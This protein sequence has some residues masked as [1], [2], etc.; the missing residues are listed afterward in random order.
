M[1]LT[2]LQK[3]QNKAESEVRRRAHTARRRQYR[4]AVT[5][6]DTDAEVQALRAAADAAQAREEEAFNRRRQRIAALQEQIVALQ[7]EM[8]SL[9]RGGDTALAEAR[10]QSRSAND[11]WRELKQ[12]KERDVDQRFPDMQGQAEWYAAL[13]QPPTDVQAAM[14]EARR[15]ATVD[16]LKPKKARKADP[17]PM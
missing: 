7:A 4:E 8:E 13:W 14:M 9:Q 12:R 10:V 6:I 3:A 1:A 2:D 17:L 11:A 15:T 16:I 5:A